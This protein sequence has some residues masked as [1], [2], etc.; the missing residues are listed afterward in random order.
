MVSACPGKPTKEMLAWHD[1][2]VGMFFHYD[3]EVF[4]PSFYD[5]WEAPL[6]D[7]SLWNPTHLDTDQWVRTAVAAGARYCMLTAKHMTG[8]CLWPTKQHD[9]HVGNAPCKRD[10]VGE[11]VASCRKYGVKPG[12]YYSLGSMHLER[13]Y[14]KPD[15]TLDHEAMNKILLA[16]LT[17]LIENYGPLVELWFDGGILRPELGGPAVPEL[18]NRLAPE[19][20]CFGGCPGIKN[21]LRWSGS[22]Q[23]VAVPECWSC[24]HFLTENEKITT[25]APGDPRDPVWAP[26]E[27]DMPSRDVLSA[28]MGGWMW[29]DYD[30]KKTYSPEYLF[31]RYLTSVG[32]NANLLIGCLPDVTGQIS[33]D[34]VE[35]F[36]GFGELVRQR[37]GVHLGQA[38]EMKDNTMTVN[39]SGIVDASYLEMEEDQTDGQKV[40]SWVCE[41][42]W[43]ESWCKGDVDRWV[44]IAQGQSIGHKRIVQLDHLLGYAFRLRILDALGPVNMK[45]F[46]VYGKRT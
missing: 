10:V 9:Y 15:G 43:P 35:A 23:G 13:M 3:I 7:V 6:P 21:I 5:S 2:E 14:R 25:D 24:A 31:S 30:A 12:L 42:R 20:I 40:L 29:R 28:F 33:Q 32:R 22:E 16:Q 19:T 34:Q 39:L 11:F 1:L 46:R 38:T 45:A 17:E 37:L 44:P 18:I 41:V 26:V 4:D 36:Q 27:V 8:F